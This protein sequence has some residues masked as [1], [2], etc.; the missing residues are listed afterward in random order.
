[1]VAVTTRRLHDINRSG[2]WQLLNLMP[3]IGFIVML[4]FTVQDSQSGKNQ[5][6]EN[7]KID[8]I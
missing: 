8:K 4:V 6:G 1:M 2:W 7:P 3:L 5:Y